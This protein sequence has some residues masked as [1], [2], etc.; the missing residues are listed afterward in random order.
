[1]PA[2]SVSPV[3]ALSSLAKRDGLADSGRSALLGRLAD[4]LE[5]AG[6]AAGLVVRRQERGAVAGLAGEHPRDRHLAAVG[7]VLRLE[8]IGDRVGAAL[9]AE[10]LRRFGNARQFMAQ[11]LQQPQH[12]VGARRGSHQHRA[13]QPFAQF[14]GE[15]VEHL[16]ARR[17]DVF[18]Q[19]LH[20]LVV[21][22]GERFQHGEARRLLAV[23]DV[24][25]E[26]DDF[27][28]ERAPCRQR[29]VRARDRRSR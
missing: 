2:V 9:H 16:V 21:M 18:E 6:D 26:R 25:F 10:A 22:V 11:R 12:A 27:A 1:M 17:L 4:E 15:I 20:Q 13:D 7:R 29:R 5:H 14:A 23:G 3:L 28:K 24:A 8:H 19:L